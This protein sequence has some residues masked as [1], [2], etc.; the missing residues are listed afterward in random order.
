M[1]RFNWISRSAASSPP[2]A[3]RQQRS[4]EFD[5]AAEFAEADVFVGR[6]LVVVGIDDRHDQERGLK[7]FADR[8]D[9]KAAAKHG[10]D[11]EFVVGGGAQNADDALDARIVKRC[12]GGRWTKGTIGAAT[13]TVVLATVAGVAFTA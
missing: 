8:G 3:F 11:A 2:A 1:D 6:V 13:L 12:G 5:A 10:R 7:D 9:G 4:V